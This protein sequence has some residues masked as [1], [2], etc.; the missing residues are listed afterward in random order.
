LIAINCE[1]HLNQRWRFYFTGDFISPLW[2]GVIVL[3]LSRGSINYFNHYKFS[4]IPILFDLRKNLQK[5]ARTA[6]FSDWGVS[7]PWVKANEQTEW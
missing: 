1:R 2:I 7:C 4:T 3:K 5:K 6:F